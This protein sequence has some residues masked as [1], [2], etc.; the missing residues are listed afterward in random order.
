[1]L[2]VKFGKLLQKPDQ[3]SL[4]KEGAHISRTPRFLLE[5]CQGARLDFLGCWNLVL[6][7][8]QDP[9]LTGQQS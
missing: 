4:S 7:C 9:R 8:S 2:V 1:M 6:G 5:S 3:T